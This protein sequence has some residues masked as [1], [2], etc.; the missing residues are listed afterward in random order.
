MIDF[1]LADFADAEAIG[2]PGQ[3]TFRVRARAGTHHA[4][5]WMEKEQLAALG[6]A[7]SRLLAERSKERASS[8]PSRVSVGVFPERPDIELHVVR[9]GLDFEEE[10]EHVVVLADDR[11]AL[12]QGDTPAFRME[13]SREHARA[14]VTQIAEA[15]AAGRPLCPLCGRPLE[16]DGPHFCPGSNGHSEELE[17]PRPED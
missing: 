1:G 3:R 9:L 16:G 15:V 2:E 11:E 4:A 10:D 7:I 5:L 6:R 17:I 8:P 12:E 13:I 14:L